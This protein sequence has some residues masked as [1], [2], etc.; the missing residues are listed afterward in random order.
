MFST[1]VVACSAGNLKATAKRGAF[2]RVAER[3]LIVLF[4]D[5]HD[6]AVDPI[7]LMASLIF[8]L[9]PEG[10]GLFNDPC[11]A[12]VRIHLESEASQIFEFFFL[13][14]GHRLR[15]HRHIVDKNIELSL[16]RPPGQAAAESK[17]RHCADSRTAAHRRPSMGVEFLQICR[18]HPHF[19]LHDDIDGLL[20]GERDRLNRLDVLRDILPTSPSPRVAAVMRM[21]FWYS[22]TILSP[23]IFS[24]QRYD[25]A[26]S[27]YAGRKIVYARIKLAHLFGAE[28]VIERPLRDLVPHF[29]E[30]GQGACPR[31]AARANRTR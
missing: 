21:P 14:R 12:K 31:R 28:R 2:S 4:V 11:D 23:S 25:G 17:R 30:A 15:A 7:F 19:S 6:N 24:S 5:F 3:L 29:L 9:F 22:N 20:E 16:R 8:P 13:R 1:T 27:P 26:T 18:T 10:D